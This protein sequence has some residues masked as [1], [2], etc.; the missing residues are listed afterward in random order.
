MN[1]YLQRI[2]HSRKITARHGPLIS[3]Q[4]RDYFY[5]I[6]KYSNHLCDL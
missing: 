5:S 6:S 1:S 2:L 3:V 4:L